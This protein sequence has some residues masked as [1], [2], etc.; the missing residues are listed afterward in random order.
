MGI[1]KDLREAKKAAKELQGQ[2]E[3]LQ[4]ESGAPTGLKGAL[5]MMKQAPGMMAQATQAL[6]DVQA[7]QA[8]AAR[9][10]TEGVPATAKLLA[11]RDAGMTMTGMGAGMDSP[12]ADL[13]LEVTI[14]GSDPFRTTVRAAVPRFQ[15]ARLAP[16]ALLPV[17]IDP[18]DHSKLVVDWNAPVV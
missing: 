16:G 8:E 15:M 18:L 11:V 12:V 13:D 5:E 17:R 14:P 3:E 6:H 10:Q 9:L 1:F 7:Q 4:R 2:A